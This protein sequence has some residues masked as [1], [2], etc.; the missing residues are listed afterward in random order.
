MNANA[1]RYAPHPSH[2]TS[3]AHQHLRLVTDTGQSQPDAL[4]LPGPRGLVERGLDRVLVV[5]RPLVLAHL[6]SLHR[7]YGEDAPHHVVRLLERRYLTL[8]TTTG[9]S[10][11]A[12]A[13]VPAIGTGVTLALSGAET[14]GFIEATA[15]YAQSL[16]EVHGIAVSDPDRARALVM[17]LMLGKE[18]ADLVT[19]FSLQASGQS[20][21]SL[22]WGEVVTSVLPRAAVGPVADRLK[23]SFIKSFAKKGSAS[24]IGKALPFG[25]GA[26]I[27]GV[28]NHVLGRRVIAAS[29]A[30]FG[31][32]PLVLP[33][34]LTAGSADV[35][36]HTHGATPVNYQ[37]ET[38]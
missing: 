35:A 18:G 37:I 29:R 2:L 3:G 20:T 6:R 30:A 16:A 23:S 36:A 13:V 26:A 32:P 7:R 15:L 17:G 8:V 5:Q 22:Y 12:T 34:A 10:I 24:F 19:Q 1:P 14:L 11:G 4:H 28:G 31:Q 38:R 25:V 27:G 21:R 9:A 33:G